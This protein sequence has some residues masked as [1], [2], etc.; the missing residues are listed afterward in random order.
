MPFNL[1]PAPRAEFILWQF[2][3]K[4]SLNPLCPH[5]HLEGNGRNE[6]NGL[7][8]YINNS[9]F[10][11]M[12]CEEADVLEMIYNIS[13][14]S[15]EKNGKLDDV[16]FIHVSSDEEKI[17]KSAAWFSLPEAGLWILQWDCRL[18]LF[19]GMPADTLINHQT[20]GNCLGKGYYASIAAI[21]SSIF[22]CSMPPGD[23]YIHYYISY[24]GLLFA[25]P[26][27]HGFGP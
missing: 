11:L 6:A 2:V 1:S 27:P 20:F 24:P 3:N 21:L 9:S 15:E 17:L 18:G 13:Y 16:W 23:K 10:M 22:Y 25:V 5:F 26:S 4:G 14:F 8:N 7:I 12:K 19:R